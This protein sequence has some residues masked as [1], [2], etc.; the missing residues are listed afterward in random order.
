MHPLIT[1][2]KLCFEQFRGSVYG[3]VHAFLSVHSL[4]SELTRFL[5][6]YDRENKKSKSN[7]C[8]ILFMS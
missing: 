3:L 5:H 2:Y 7:L 6:L 1:N 4:S 8:F